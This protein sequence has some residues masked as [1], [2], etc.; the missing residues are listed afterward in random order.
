MPACMR[1]KTFE[2]FDFGQL[3]LQKLQSIKPAPENF[4]LYV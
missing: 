4:R 3:A 1:E 2:K